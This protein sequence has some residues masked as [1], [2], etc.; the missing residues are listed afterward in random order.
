[1][2]L[3]Y[4]RQYVNTPPNLGVVLKK[5]LGGHATLRIEEEAHAS[6]KVDFMEGLLERARGCRVRH[7][8]KGH[9]NWSPRGRRGRAARV[10][11]YTHIVACRK[12]K[13]KQH[14][15]VNS[16]MQVTKITQRI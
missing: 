4:G 11:E 8:E 15:R 2:Q 3:W 10:S 9:Y 16:G 1:M 12:L 5:R 14:V 13:D 7:V 6:S